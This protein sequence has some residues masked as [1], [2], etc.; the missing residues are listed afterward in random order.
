MKYDNEDLKDN[1]T[2]KQRINF[3]LTIAKNEYTH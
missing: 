3:K 1:L 2:E